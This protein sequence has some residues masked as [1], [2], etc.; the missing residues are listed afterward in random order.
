MS[1]NIFISL[2]N[3]LISAG[4]PVQLAMGV[5]ILVGQNQADV[6][7][8]ARLII[9]QLLHAGRQVVVIDD[10]LGSVGLRVRSDRRAHG[11]AIPIFGGAY[12]DLP[13]P[14]DM[15][16]LADVLEQKRVS[17]VL[18]LQGEPTSF[19]RRVGQLLHKFRINKT[20]LTVVI[21]PGWV[22]GDD[23]CRALGDEHLSGSQHEQHL[24]A[25]NPTQEWLRRQ[26]SSIDAMVMHRM[27]ALD[28]Y[29]QEIKHWYSLQATSATNQLPSLASLATGQAIVISAP[30]LVPIIT[31][32]AQ[33]ETAL[34]A[35]GEAVCREIVDPTDLLEELQ[36]Q[37]ALKEHRDRYAVLEQARSGALVSTI[38]RAV[39]WPQAKI[40]ATLTEHHLTPCLRSTEKPVL[41]PSETELILRTFTEYQSVKA[42]VAATGIPRPVVAA[43]LATVPRAQISAWKR[44]ALKRYQINYC[45]NK[46][47]PAGKKS[48]IAR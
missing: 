46:K 8:S 16:V 11:F 25:V 37:Q 39:G 23:S 14:D 41:D 33:P 4:A 5:A 12:Q 3:P 27:A 22:L 7:A 29:Q 31:L 38:A 45:A 13:M 47:Q 9:E 48:A 36:N 1:E 20:P 34:E 44:L 15:E 2:T 17:A 18:C 43:I 10:H 28:P 35:A 24:V 30:S 19:G 21:L 40:I 32:I 26:A 42:I 6:R